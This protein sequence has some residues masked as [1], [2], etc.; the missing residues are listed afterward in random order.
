MKH[1]TLLLTAIVLG[2][3]AASSATAADSWLYVSLLKQKQIVAF[4]R[5]RESGRLTKSMTTDCPAEPAAM[6]FSPNRRCLYVSFRSTGQLAAY[7]IDQ[8]T[9]KLSLLNVVD[10]GDD[11]AYLQVD[12]TGTFLL[13]AYYASNKVCVHRLSDDGTISEAPVQTVPT[14]EKAHGIAIDSKNRTV[15]VTHTGANRIYQFTFDDKTGHL[16]A[17]ETPFKQTPDEDHPRHIVLHPTDNWAYVSNEA[18]DSI[19]VY[20]VKKTKGKLKSRQTVSTIPEDFDGARNSTARCELTPDGKF[21]YVA[22]RGHDSIA[23]FAI[24]QISGDVTLLGQFATEQTPRSFS[25]SSDSRF[26]YAAGQGSGKVA[27]FRIRPNG[28]LERFDT[29]ESGPVSWWAIVV[30]TAE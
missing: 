13:T 9:G 14:A 8:S 19:G 12:R 4:E 2:F 26:L 30:D 21:V 25:I 18:G 16:T 7:K 22:N 3:G 1:Q 23:A 6:G 24:D 5:D 20:S 15:F 11:P 17:N 27:A 28:G 29:Y 10:G